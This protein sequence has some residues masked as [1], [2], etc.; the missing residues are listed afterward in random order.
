MKTARGVSTG[1]EGSVVAALCVSTPARASAPTPWSG[2][3]IDVI[4]EDATALER[5]G[6]QG[7]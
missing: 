3:G 4:Q 1:R 5:H 7:G 6:S 2:V